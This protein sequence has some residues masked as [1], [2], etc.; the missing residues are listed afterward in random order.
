MNYSN[1]APQ[2]I[3]KLSKRP[4]VAF[5]SLFPK[6]VEYREK[7]GSPEINVHLGLPVSGTILLDATDDGHL[8][9]GF[10]GGEMW[11]AISKIQFSGYVVSETPKSLESFGLLTL[12]YTENCVESK[13]VRSRSGEKLKIT[14]EQKVFH[15][16]FM[17]NKQAF[18]SVRNSK[19]ITLVPYNKKKEQMKSTPGIEILKKED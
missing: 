12:Q 7:P 13:A 8:L 10:P 15:M 2:W 9:V 5:Y 14:K 6:Y 11:E 1:S 4:D 17:L 3:A 16:H 19:K 18:L